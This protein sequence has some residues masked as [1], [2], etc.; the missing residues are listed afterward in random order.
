MTHAPL[1]R[2]PDWKPRLTAWLVQAARRPF[3]E[4]EHDCA[5]FFAGA[6]EAMTG[7]DPAA[8]WRGR[9]PSTAAGLRLLRRAGFADHLALAAACLPEVPAAY[10]RTGDGAV[11][12]TQDGPALGL[13]QGEMIFVLGP[14]GLR[15]V[16]R[17]LASRAFR[18]G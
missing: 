7:T 18:V 13:V 1:A 14:T 9:Y 5:L 3:A 12:E 10:A 16:P 11:V 6:V 4:G 2:L 15:L 8:A 17:S